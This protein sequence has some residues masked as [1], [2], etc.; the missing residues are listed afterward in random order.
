MKLTVIYMQIYSCLFCSAIVEEC[1]NQ[2][3][4][5]KDDKEA[6]E[7]DEG[8]PEQKLVDLLLHVKVNASTQSNNSDV[9]T[10]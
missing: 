3:F 6:A 5:I 2:Y 10:H 7:R 1:V 8:T 4:D 9:V